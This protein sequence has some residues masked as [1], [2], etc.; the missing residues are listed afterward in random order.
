MKSHKLQ[1]SASMSHRVWWWKMTVS[2]T[3]DSTR[4]ELNQRWA[5]TPT[6]SKSCPKTQSGGRRSYLKWDL[7]ASS[8]QSRSITWAMALYQVWKIWRMPR[9]KEA[10]P[11]TNQS[12]LFSIEWQMSSED[13]LKTLLWIKESDPLEMRTPSSS[14]NS[15]RTISNNSWSKSRSCQSQIRMQLRKTAILCS[16]R[17]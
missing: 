12:K 6:F 1:N 9:S 11:R 15:A 17:F 10:S 14:L 4:T 8:S 13:G 3:S 2:L 5:L 7:K 16:E